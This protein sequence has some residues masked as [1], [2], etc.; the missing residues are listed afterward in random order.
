MTGSTATARRV[1]MKHATS[2]TSASTNETMMYVAGSVAVTPTNADLITR[3]S[4][5]EAASQTVNPAATIASAYRAMSANTAPAAA[6]SAMRMP[7][8]R[9]RSATE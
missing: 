6:P 7:I 8:S 1:G 9:V 5:N 3:V 2:A 4:A